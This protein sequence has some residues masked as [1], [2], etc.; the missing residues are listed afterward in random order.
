MLHAIDLESGRV[1]SWS[2]P[3]MMC[4]HAVQAYE[5]GDD[6]V[7]D[8]CVFEDA[9]I[10]EDLAL[11]RLRTG[12]PTALGEVRRYVMRRGASHAEVESLGVRLELPQIHPGKVGADQASVAWG[13]G[14]RRDAPPGFFNRT[15]RLDLETGTET[16]WL[17]DRSIQLEPL[18]VARPGAEREDDGVLL[19]PT[20]ADEDQGSVIAV[21]DARSMES[22]ATIHAPQVIPFGF[23]AAFAAAP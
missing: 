16:E 22:V 4:F 12:A 10:M 20:L 11:A 2:I 5:R 8:L 14:M 15:V 3:A 1:A 21:L 13:A 19:V 18:Y 17:R 23:H 7:L 9:K 6:V